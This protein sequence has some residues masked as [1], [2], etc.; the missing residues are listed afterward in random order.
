MR[1][2]IVGVGRGGEGDIMLLLEKFKRDRD[3]VGIS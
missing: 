2:G 3:V 1:R